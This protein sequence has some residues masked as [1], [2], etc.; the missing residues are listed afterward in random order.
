MPA[1]DGAP[2]FS[3]MQEKKKEAAEARS[4]AF[5][6]VPQPNDTPR[7]TRLAG[8]LTWQAPSNIFICHLWCNH[9][10]LTSF[11]LPHLPQTCRSFQDLKST[12]CHT[13]Q[14]LKSIPMASESIF[15]QLQ[16][17]DRIVKLTEAEPLEITSK[18][19]PCAASKIASAPKGRPNLGAGVDAATRGLAVPLL[20][21]GHIF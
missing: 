2:I 3:K 18:D 6:A 8:P 11:S 7:V 5:L 21:F 10:N 4:P 13:P 20:L 16:I 19:P 9:R 14:H 17:Q 15:L 12:S 1:Q